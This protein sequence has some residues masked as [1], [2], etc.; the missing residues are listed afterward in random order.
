MCDVVA[1]SWS[2]WGARLY[3]LKAMRLFIALTALFISLSLTACDPPKPDRSIS[4]A[5][6]N[7]PPILMIFKG[8]GGTSDGG[9]AGAA[10]M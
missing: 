3:T 8:D 6:N 2:R 10:D 9:D 7:P 5:D 1:V 4:S